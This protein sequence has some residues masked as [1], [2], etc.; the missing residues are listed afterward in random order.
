MWRSVAGDPF[1]IAT[2]PRASAFNWMAEQLLNDTES[3]WSQG[4]SMTKHGV[5][6]EMRDSLRA[7]EQAA[8]AANADGELQSWRRAGF[9]HVPDESDDG[10]TI[11]DF[12]V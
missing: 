7:Q 6:G 8:A 12:E 11:S 4:T 2:N 9:D 1:D 3:M 5:R 10:Q